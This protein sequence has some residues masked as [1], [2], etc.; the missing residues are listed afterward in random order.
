VHDFPADCTFLSDDDK[1]RVIKRLKEDK[2]ASAGTEE[3]QMK[4][5][6]QSL[7]D[8]KTYTAS[9]MYMGV[10]GALYAF[11]IFLPSIIKELGFTATKAQLL[12]VPRKFKF[13]ASR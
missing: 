5:F 4:Y 12:S 8:W 11:A 3:F 7:T 1:A 2:Q 6:Y 13:P 9:L 10:D